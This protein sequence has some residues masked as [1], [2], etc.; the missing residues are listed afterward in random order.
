MQRTFKTG[1]AVRAT[2]SPMYRGL[3]VMCFVDD[4]ALA[5]VDCVATPPIL[6]AKRGTMLPAIHPDG[7]LIFPNKYRE[8]VFLSSGL[9]MSYTPPGAGNAVPR[10][11]NVFVKPEAYRDVRANGALA[12]Q[13]RLR[14]GERQFDEPWVDH[15]GRSLSNRPVGYN[16]EV[17][18]DERFPEHW[19]FFG[20]GQRA[21]R[22]SREP[23]SPRPPP[24]FNAIRR[25]PP[26]RTPS[27]NSI[28]P[29]S[30]SQSKRAHSSRRTCR[31]KPRRRAHQRRRPSRRTAARRQL[32]L[33]REASAGS[34]IVAACW[35]MTRLVKRPR[36]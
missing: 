26:S 10:F 23:V 18:D 32:P 17:R 6:L 19:R 16:V 20:F 36:P 33:A 7:R 22:S 5:R 4:G 28:R 15:Q 9:G 2:I 21:R 27:S 29:Y 30:K 25:T 11:T 35:R 24:A 8:W 31:P 34:R 1:R 12:R 13:S 14:A 3:L